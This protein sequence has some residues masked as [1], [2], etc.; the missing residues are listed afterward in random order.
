MW[1]ALAGGS[2]VIDNLVPAGAVGGTATADLVVD[3]DVPSGEYTVAVTAT[4]D[5]AAPQTDDC[6]QL[7][8]VVGPPSVVPIYIIQGDG[9]ASLFD[10]DDVLTER[11]RAA[12]WTPLEDRRCRALRSNPLHLNSGRASNPRWCVHWVQSL[13]L[14]TIGPQTPMC[15]STRTAKR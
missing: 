15:C 13:S 12:A 4:N 7:V 10:G 2:I 8:T 11:L 3:A 5:D 14:T 1:P 9:D 6:T